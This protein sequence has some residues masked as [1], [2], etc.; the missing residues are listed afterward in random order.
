VIVQ[1][2]GVAIIALLIVLYAPDP[3]LAYVQEAWGGII[4]NAIPNNVGTFASFR[5][6]DVQ[7]T[8]GTVVAVTVYFAASIDRRVVTEAEHMRVHTF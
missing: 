8:G 1:G 2:A 7:S 6:T 3:R 5:V 4:W